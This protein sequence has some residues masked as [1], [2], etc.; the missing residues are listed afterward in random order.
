VRFTLI[1]PAF[2]WRGG[3]PLL[4]QPTCTSP[5]GRRARGPAAHLDRQGPPRL[6]PA[7]RHPLSSP[8]AGVYPTV[9]EPLSWRNPVQWWRAGRR[10][11][12]TSDVII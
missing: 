6:L 8:E 2:P 7:Q 10:F 4:T 1:G 3:I 5:H 12:G 11:G 9:Q